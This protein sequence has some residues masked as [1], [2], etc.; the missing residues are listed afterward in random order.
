MHRFQSDSRSRAPAEFE[1]VSGGIEYGFGGIQL[2]VD[3]IV[4]INIIIIIITFIIIIIIM[5]II[6][7]IV[8][9]YSLS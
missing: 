4:I 5:I 1:S 9:V 3:D 2:V 8:N 6:I 7:I